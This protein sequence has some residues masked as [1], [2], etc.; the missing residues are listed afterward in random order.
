MNKKKNNQKNK[1]KENKRKRK[2]SSQTANY[3]KR[4]RTKNKI[5]S[6]N[7]N[8]SLDIINRAKEKEE[9]DNV[10]YYSN[11]DS[12]SE[13]EDIDLSPMINESNIHL[14]NF[15]EINNTKDKYLPCEI[16]LYSLIIARRAF[17]LKNRLNKEFFNLIV[18]LNFVRNIYKDY[19][20]DQL[21]K[22]FSKNCQEILN[23]IDNEETFNH[24]Q[25][26]LKDEKNQS[27][28][29]FK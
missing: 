6:V 21:T 11:N 10:N 15:S 9:E 22:C 8:K 28:I 1:N 18:K 7:L 2:S 24:L 12:E 4:S 17:A 23:I 27:K 20:I 5:K 29:K 14:L 13:F 3:K 19:S 25:K 16:I 26:F